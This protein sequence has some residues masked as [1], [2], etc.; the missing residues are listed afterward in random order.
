MFC[1]KIQFGRALR[2]HKH[3]LE[4]TSAV[5]ASVAF[6]VV[7][8]YSVKG[9]VSGGRGGAMRELVVCLLLP[10]SEKVFTIR[11]RLDARSQTR[12]FET[13][14]NRF[15][16]CPAR[17][18]RFSRAS[19]SGAQNV[20]VLLS[21]SL[22]LSRPLALSLSHEASFSG[23]ERVQKEK[24]VLHRPLRAFGHTLRKLKSERVA[25]R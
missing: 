18:R 2:K 21:L 9:K 20:R 11:E 10:L 13:K 1:L 23:R 8:G 22:S 19:H 17:R 6:A 4:H 3:K 7:V 5:G 25:D 12:V 15:S 24:R 14:T 16:S